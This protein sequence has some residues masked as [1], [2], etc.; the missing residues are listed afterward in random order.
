MRVPAHVD[1]TGQPRQHVSGTHAVE[2][3]VPSYRPPL[4]EQQRP[5]G[6][7][8]SQLARTLLDD[9][10]NCHEVSCCAYGS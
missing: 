5:S 4:G 7:Q 9:E 1:L 10:P 2:E 6:I 3:K 8:T